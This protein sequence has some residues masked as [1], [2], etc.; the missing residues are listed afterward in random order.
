MTALQIFLGEFIGG[1]VLILLGN[2]SVAN[3][4]LKHSKGENGGW[5]VVALGWSMAAYLAVYISAPVSGAHLNPVVTVALVLKGM[6]SLN[7]VPVYLAGQFGGA[8]MGAWLVYIAYKSHF[9]STSDGIANRSCFC[10]DPAIRNTGSNLLTEIV[11]T[12][13]LVFAV[14]NLAKPEVGLGS[15]SS[16]PV[17]FIVLAIA[18]CLGGPTGCAMNPARDLGPRIVYALLPIKHKSGNDWG[19]AWIPIAGPF[20]GGLAALALKTL[21]S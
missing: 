21:I 5:I 3:V 10:T 16:L 15:L 17:A 13:V 11:A 18:L 20:V 9:H 6:C 8:M 12:F 7:Q 14:L 1:A 4:V 2:G 19:Y